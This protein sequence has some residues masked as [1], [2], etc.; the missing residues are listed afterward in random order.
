MA[1]GKKASLTPFLYAEI[2]N[3]GQRCPC[4]GG[5]SAAQGNCPV[6]LFAVIGKEKEQKKRGKG[7][8]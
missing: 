8:E 4:M 2:K 7:N 1:S 6:F 5:F 3:T